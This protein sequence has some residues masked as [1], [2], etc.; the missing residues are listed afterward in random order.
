MLVWGRCSDQDIVNRN[1]TGKRDYRPNVPCPGDITD[2]MTSIKGV[3]TQTS[4][5][6]ENWRKICDRG[7]YLIILVGWPILKRTHQG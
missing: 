2:V 3:K 7:Y 5:R 6:I 4:K 1:S